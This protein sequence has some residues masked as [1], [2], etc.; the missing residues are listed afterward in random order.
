MSVLVNKAAAETL[1]TAGAETPRLQGLH[2]DG[3]ALLR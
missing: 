2:P 3:G 1:T